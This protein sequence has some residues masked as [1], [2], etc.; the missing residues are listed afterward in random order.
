MGIFALQDPLRE[1]VPAAVKQCHKSGITVR[2]VTGDNIDTARAI[3]KEANIIPE[4]F[5]QEKGSR[6]V[7]MTG[8]QF[9]EAVGGLIQEETDEKD[10]EGNPV[11][12]DKVAN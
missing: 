9:R 5:D 10:D 4:D 8:K 3:S 6:Y 7:C 12:V 11:K 1:G 2:M